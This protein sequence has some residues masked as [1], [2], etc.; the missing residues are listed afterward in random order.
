MHQMVEHVFTHLNILSPFAASTDEFQ[1]PIRP[2]QELGAP[3]R[4]IDRVSLTTTPDQFDD[5]VIDYLDD[6]LGISDKGDITF[7]LFRDAVLYTSIFA[8]APATFDEL[9]MAHVLTSFIPR[10]KNVR[11]T[12]EFLE[13]FGAIELA[14]EV[15]GWSPGLSRGWAIDRLRE[16]MSQ[17]NLPISQ[18]FIDLMAEETRGMT[19]HRYHI[20]PETQTKLAHVLEQYEQV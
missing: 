11:M 4:P 6:R 20:L 3:H 16:R 8:P 15:P 17:D 18:A 13:D 7:E 2:D 12:A 1:L 9:A 14:E 5:I 19:T 10:A